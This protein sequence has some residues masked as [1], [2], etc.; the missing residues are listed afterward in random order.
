MWTTRTKEPWPAYLPLIP[1]LIIG[2][3]IFLIFCLFRRKA[4]RDRGEFEC[5]VIIVI[6]SAKIFQLRK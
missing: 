3:I 4:R 1:N 5:E 2:L 6:I